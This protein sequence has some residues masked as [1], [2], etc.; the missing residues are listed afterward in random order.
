MLPNPQDWVNP[1]R[2]LSKTTGYQAVMRQLK[3]LIKTGVDSCS[4]TKDYFDG[5]MTEARTRFHG[6]EFAIVKFGVG[7][8][9]A[10]RLQQALFGSGSD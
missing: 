9:A 1:E 8:A 6:R 7:R 3:V 10:N 5:V 4:I 2:I